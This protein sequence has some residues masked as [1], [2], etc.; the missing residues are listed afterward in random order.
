MVHF[1]L[2]GGDSNK[3]CLSDDVFL[4][5]QEPRFEEDPADAFLLWGGYL[6]FD[7]N[8]KLVALLSA[9]LKRGMHDVS[10]GI[11]GFAKPCSVEGNSALKRVWTEVRSSG[12]GVPVSALQS[13]DECENLRCI[14]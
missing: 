3:V 11:L 6:Y 12:G 10:H 2:E 7:D 5:L 13:E 4:Q 9:S 8:F 14:W 1:K